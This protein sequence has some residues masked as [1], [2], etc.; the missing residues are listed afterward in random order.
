MRARYGMK[1]Q[2]PLDKSKNW[3]VQDKQKIESAGLKT[4]EGYDEQEVEGAN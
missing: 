1:T 2:T 4:T 3:K